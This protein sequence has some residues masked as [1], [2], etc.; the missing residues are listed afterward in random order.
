ML[1]VQAAVSGIAKGLDTHLKTLGFTPYVPPDLDKKSF[2]LVSDRDR[3]FVTF[4][5][6]NGSLRI[7]YCSD[8]VGLLYADASAE[9]AADSEYTRLS[10]SLLELDGAA[11]R[12]LNYVVEDFAET[13]ASKFQN[14]QKPKQQKKIPAAV[15]KTAVKHGAYYDAAS[16]GSRFT[17]VYPELREPYKQNIE[18]YGE[19][20][21]EEFFKLYGTPAV[22]A[23]VK[24][25][26]PL[27]MKKLFNLLNEIYDNGVNDVQSLIAVSILG[28]MYQD[29]TLLA[30]CV[31]YMDGDLCVT[32][33]RVSK[34]LGSNGA[35]GARMRLENPPRY[36]PKKDKKTGGLLSQLMGGGGASPFG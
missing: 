33:I 23:T 9:N 5:G 26:N 19:F 15:S 32:V 34:Y 18:E 25:N 7:E 10:L 13:L 1:T 8:T 30:N 2:P 6:K 28:S 12:D 3:H 11:E 35:K 29:E 36:K 20:L 17:A 22:A 31:D 27:K 24:E 14:G 16:F 4:S 21:P